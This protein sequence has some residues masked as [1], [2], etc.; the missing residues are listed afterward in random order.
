MSENGGGDNLSLGVHLPDG[1]KGS[2]LI[3]EGTMLSL[4]HLGKVFLNVF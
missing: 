4:I 1:I 2:I 3:I